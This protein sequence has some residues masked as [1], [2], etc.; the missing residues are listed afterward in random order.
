MTN[1]VRIMIPVAVA[2]V[3]K[4]KEWRQSEGGK[5]RRDTRIRQALL[6]VAVVIGGKGKLN[7]RASSVADLRTMMENRRGCASN[8]LV[9][10]MVNNLTQAARSRLD[11]EDRM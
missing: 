7:P 1:T 8:H 10:L 2:G 9:Y 4:P 11:G 5:L 6:L 3:P